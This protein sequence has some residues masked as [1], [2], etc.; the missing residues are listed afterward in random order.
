MI[1][2]YRFPHLNCE[3]KGTKKVGG[4]QATTHFRALRKRTAD[5]DP[6]SG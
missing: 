3:Y 6:V 5:N 1:S 2:G 4:M